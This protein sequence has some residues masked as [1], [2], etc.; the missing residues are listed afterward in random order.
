MKSKT[1]LLK[2]IK[3]FPEEVQRDIVLKPYGKNPMSLSVIYF[4]VKMDTRIGKR[5]LKR[6]L[7]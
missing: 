7:K 2:L 5:L 4:E 1:K 3:Q 6:L